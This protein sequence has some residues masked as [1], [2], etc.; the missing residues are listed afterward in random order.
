MTDIISPDWQ[1][2]DADNTSPAPNG[3]QGGYAPSQV[4]PIL[5]T[6]R[7]AI[8]RAYV[9]SNAIYTTTGTGNAYV[10][11]YG[12]APASY[13]KGI[14]YRFYVHADNTGPVTLNIN[15]LGAKSVLSCNGLAL[16]AGQWKASRLVEVAYNGTAF[17]VLSNHSH[18]ARFTGTL[19]LQ[20]TGTANAIFSYDTSNNFVLATSANSSFLV[21]GGSVLTTG[22]GPIADSQ[23]PT[24]MAGKTFTSPVTLTMN[25]APMMLMKPTANTGLAHINWQK[26]NGDAVGYLGM[27]NAEGN[28][29]FRRSTAGNIDIHAGSTGSITLTANTVTLA[30][31]TLTLN[32]NT[33]W[34]GA[35]FDPAT[36]ADLSGADFTGWVG[37][38]KDGVGC[39]GL[40]LGRV[41]NFGS[42]EFYNSAGTNVGYVGG[43]GTTMELG[44]YGGMTG[45]TTNGTFTASG[46]ITAYSDERL[47]DNIRTL[48]NA[49]EMTRNMRGV[50]YVMNGED[51]IGVIAQEFQKVA[52]ELVLEMDDDMKTLS[53]NYGNTVG[54]LIEAIK[55]LDAE[56]TRLKADREN[57]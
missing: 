3:V 20:S 36:K 35:N 10:L 32:G 28:L 43:Y 31:N 13:K 41:D 21:N 27:D 15:G 44:L 45:W 24:S 5:R 18:D 2:L 48:D 51:G 9:Q 4:A 19:T 34:H 25:T 57:R 37:A 56:V 54:I 6:M 14:I 26:S 29:A 1:E 47:K 40:S 38:W 49:L 30:A 52:P 12:A 39:V 23:I 22:S 50:R 7:G 46:N 11:T 8:K 33:V 16:T 42:V 17:D 53:V 55:E